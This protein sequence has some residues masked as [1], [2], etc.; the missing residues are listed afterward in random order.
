MDCPFCRASSPQVKV[1]DTR[2]PV[3]GEVRRQRLCEACGARFGTVERISAHD[4]PVVKRGGRGT[5][6]FPRSK[7]RTGVK[8]AAPVW[9]LDDGELDSIVERVVKR[10][11][12]SPGEPVTS[13]DIADIVLR[14]LADDRPATAIT[15]IRFAIVALGRTGLQT[16]FRNLRDFLA[17]LEQEY[18]PP[19]VD[20]LSA[21]P[22][23]VIKRNGNASAFS[24]RKLER[25]IGVA[26][27]GRG[28][29]EQ[30]K[31]L[32][33]SVAFQAAQALRGQAIV[34]SQQIAA[35][36]LKILKDRDALAYLRYGSAVKRYRSVDDFWLE[37]YGLMSVES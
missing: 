15:R 10:L 31:S 29:V 8:R 18:G 6:K 1:K 25:S 21:T 26:S 24:L 13:A 14:V 12:P 27:K 34:T 17:W 9:K 37:A 35:E 19:S 5:E 36:V 22:Y 11:R 30:V 3:V 28:S 32:A 20:T 23:E 2:T 7:L 33:S 4:T 16:Q